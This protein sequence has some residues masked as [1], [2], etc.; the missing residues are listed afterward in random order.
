[1]SLLHNIFDRVKGNIEFPLVRSQHRKINEVEGA[2]IKRVPPSLKEETDRFETGN[3][4]YKDSISHQGVDPR[5]PADSSISHSTDGTIGSSEPV[6]S[7]HNFIQKHEIQETPQIPARQ[8]YISLIGNT[9]ETPRPSSLSV[10]SP[11]IQQQK[12]DTEGE[13]KPPSLQRGNHDNGVIEDDGAPANPDELLFTSPVATHSIEIEETSENRLPVETGGL[14]QTGYEKVADLITSFRKN[15]SFPSNVEP[16]HFTVDG[17]HCTGQI[18]PP[19]SQE[20]NDGDGVTSNEKDVTIVSSAVET[21][22]E[23]T[24]PHGILQRNNEEGL[25]SSD[26]S[27]Q[28]IQYVKPQ[29]G[30]QGVSREEKTHESAKGIH[31]GTL[32]FDIICPELRD[33]VDTSIPAQPSLH[34]LFLGGV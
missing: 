33:N 27:L 1:M 13:I 7:S 29:K 8:P 4:L 11:F 17:T 28:P 12:S 14:A 19:L 22:V 9:T 31:V 32:S 26:G 10:S 15:N 20:K 2:K 5:S 23:H 30:A 34:R 16:S 6:M 21:P 18:S 3:D 24:A 25:S